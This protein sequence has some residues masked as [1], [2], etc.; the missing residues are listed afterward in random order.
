VR[1]AILQLPDAGEDGTYRSHDVLPS[2]G[3]ADG[4]VVPRVRAI[5]GARPDQDV[6]KDAFIEINEIVQM[7]L[8]RAIKLSKRETVY[9][10]YGGGGMPHRVE[11]VLAFADI[12][13]LLERERELRQEFEEER[14]GG[15]WS[16]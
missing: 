5:F 2:V 1:R 9:A 10:S 8:E 13:G 12:E 3:R 11:D 14:A 15:N 16:S 7:D 4:D 6:R